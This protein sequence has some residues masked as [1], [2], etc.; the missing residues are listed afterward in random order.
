M[1]LVLSSMIMLTGPQVIHRASGG[2]FTGQQSIDGA[3]VAGAPEVFY[4]FDQ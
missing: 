2:V 4:D 3:K 1:G